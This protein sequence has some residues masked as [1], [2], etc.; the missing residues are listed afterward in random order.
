[1]HTFKKLPNSSPTTKPTPTKIS[2]PIPAS[3][4][5]PERHR[6]IRLYPFNRHFIRVKPFAPTGKD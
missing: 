4:E 2:I 1:M 3:I 5:T 6:L